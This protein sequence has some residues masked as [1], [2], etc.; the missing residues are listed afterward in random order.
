MSLTTQISRFILI[1]WFLGQTQHV[2]QL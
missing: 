1:K 2:M